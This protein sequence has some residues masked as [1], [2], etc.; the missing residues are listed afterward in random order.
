[1]AVLGGGGVCEKGLATLEEVVDEE[2]EE[3]KAVLDVEDSCGLSSMV[4]ACL[5]CFLCK[6]RRKWCLK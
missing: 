5:S 2:E 1:M 4:I 3:E 6:R